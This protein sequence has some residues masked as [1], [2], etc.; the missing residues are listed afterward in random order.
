MSAIR[1]RLADRLGGDRF[2]LWFGPSINISST[3]SIVSVQADSMFRLERLRKSLLAD[4][5]SVAADVLG[6]SA[7]VEFSVDP[8]LRDLKSPSSSS[9]MAQATAS[10]PTIKPSVSKTHLA[11]RRRFASFDSFVEGPSN[12]VAYRST[13]LVMDRIGEISPLLI[14]GPSGVGKT[15][16]LEGIWTQTRRSGG[17]RVIYLSAEQFTTY[18]LQA[19]RG[20][21]LPSFRQKYR[22]VDVLIIDDLQFFGGKQATINELL[23]TMDA[24]SRDSR[25]LVLAADR[26]PIKLR[27]LGPELTARI[28]GGLVCSVEPLD[29]ATRIQVL[30]QLAHR[31]KTK[32]SGE[33]IEHIAERVC[34][35]ARQLT[36]A[37]NRLWVTSQALGQPISIK[38]AD[39]VIEELFPEAYSV[40]RLDDI[41]RVVCNEFDIDPEMLKSDSR[42]RHVSHP[43]MLAMW[44]ARKHTRAA[45]TEI[46]EFFGRRSHS[47]VVSAQTKVDNWVNQGEQLQCVRRECKVE[48]MLTQLEQV[49]RAS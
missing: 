34:G 2:E 19:L 21:G 3:K 45:L 22:A 27:N 48:D 44:L 43:R 33:V 13:H 37:I 18:F 40:V 14:H 23:H 32:V 16:L 31:R 17:Q 6:P 26:S 41:Q 9:L 46:S 12:Q 42:S 5:E 20:G 15:H 4:I 25:Q 38:L 10:K 7:V 47:T 36:G 35:D 49:L 24:L 39:R 1:S 11:G 30:S 8:A 29:V 28:A